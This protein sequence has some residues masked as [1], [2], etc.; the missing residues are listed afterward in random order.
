[1]SLSIQYNDT[2]G[3]D[4]YAFLFSSSDKSKAFHI[5]KNSFQTFSLSNQAA[6]AIAMEEDSIRVGF[7]SADIADVSN[8]PASS[9]DDFYLIEMFKKTGSVADRRV[10][11]ILGS[12]YFYWDGTKEISLG[13]QVTITPSATSLPNAQVPRL[14]QKG[15]VAGASSIRL[16]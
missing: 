12:Q 5:S 13:G 11:T 6:F 9:G 16:S 4:I 3:L 2:V 1:M 10:D 7:Y 15:S 8:I 14:G